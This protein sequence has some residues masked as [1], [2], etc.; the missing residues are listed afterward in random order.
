MLYKVQS[1]CRELVT[2]FAEVRFFA[3]QYQSDSVI[4]VWVLASKPSLDGGL[5]GAIPHDPA[6]LKGKTQ[7]MLGIV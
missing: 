3:K 5:V 7:A 1:C 4:Q 2:E 6:N